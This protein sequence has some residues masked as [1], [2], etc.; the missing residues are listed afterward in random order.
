[1]VISSLGSLEL[2]NEIISSVLGLIG[3]IASLITLGYGVSVVKNAIIKSDEIPDFDLQTNI[4]DGLKMAVISIVYYIIPFVIGTFFLFMN[5]HIICNFLIQCNLL[6]NYQIILLPSYNL[7][8][9]F[10]Y[11]SNKRYCNH[12]FR[13]HTLE[14]EF[15]HP[16]LIFQP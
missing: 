6:Q 13:L 7:L 14:R 10:Q 5:T 16:S 2:G 1:M 12:I 3:V 15:Q 11:Y 9:V 8:S 4:V